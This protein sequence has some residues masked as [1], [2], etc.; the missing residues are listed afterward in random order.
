MDPTTPNLPVTI[1][2]PSSIRLTN[3]ISKCKI[4]TAYTSFFTNGSINNHSTFTV[5]NK[6]INFDYLVL[7]SSEKDTGSNI[8]T[9]NVNKLSTY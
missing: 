2:P 3:C 4:S 1:P 9:I 7:Y 8:N 5:N 6:S